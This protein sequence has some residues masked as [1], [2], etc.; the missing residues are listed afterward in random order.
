MA[1]ETLPSKSTSAIAA[2]QVSALFGE[3]ATIADRLDRECYYTTDEVEDWDGERSVLFIDRLR[4]AIR[5]MG[6][7]ADMGSGLVGGGIGPM[8]QGVE[9][10]LLP[11]IY[12]RHGGGASS[13]PPENPTSHQ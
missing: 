11:P 1:R 6:L 7:I 4:E 8:R 10:W 13:Q 2:G 5:R 12:S 3:I 9:G